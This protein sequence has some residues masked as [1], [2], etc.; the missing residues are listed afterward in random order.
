[1]RSTHTHTHVQRVQSEKGGLQRI[2]PTKHT[3]ILTHKRTQTDNTRIIFVIESWEK[4]KR[5]CM[6]LYVVALTVA[7]FANTSYVVVH[8]IIIY[9]YG[10]L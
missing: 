6:R 7:L 1:M 2:H 10:V 9:I 3:H 8:H 4:M 5:V